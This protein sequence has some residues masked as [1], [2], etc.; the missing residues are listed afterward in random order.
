MAVVGSYD[1]IVG[2]GAISV[3][4]YYVL[5]LIFTTAGLIVWANILTTTEIGIVAGLHIIILGFS[6][7]SNLSLREGVTKFIPEYLT[8]GEKHKA[9]KSFKLSVLLV[10]IVAASIAAFLFLASP[11]L[12]ELVFQGQ[13]EALWIQLSAVDIWLYSVGLVFIGGMWGLNLMPR[14]SLILIISLAIRHGFSSVLVVGGFGIFGI[15]VAYVIGDLILFLAAGVAS[16]LA[17][18]RYNP[19]EFRSSGLSVMSSGEVSARSLLSFS[20]P[21]LASTMM[22]FGLGQLDK[23]FVLAQQELSELGIYNIAVGAALISAYVPSAITIALIPSLSSLTA[24][25]DMV[26]FKELSAAYTRYTSLIAIPMSF[27]LAALATAVLQIFG[28]QY[29][30]GAYPAAIM[31]IATGLTCI[32]AVLSGELIAVKR[33]RAV[34]AAYLSG[35]LAFIA[36]LVFF[37][38][39]MGFVGAAWGRAA[40]YVVLTLVLV[41]ITLRRGLFVIDKKAYLVSIL[42]SMIM[43]IVVFGIVSTIGG[44]RRQIAALPMLVLLGAFIYVI[45]LRATKILK[46]DDIH[47]LERLLPKKLGWMARWV[48]RL[49]GL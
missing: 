44:Y 35:L 8:L 36:M 30:V 15:L 31:S 6:F 24:K 22:L 17:L 42:A 26:G 1:A 41:G 25:E 38:P 16:F 43:G 48:A 5:S 2:R 27:G 37:V 14:A 12:A 4:S 11:I 32:N 23:I 46:P 18:Y 10:A 29:K 19:P 13:A 45:V 34:M 7:L 40:M 3:Y 28:P 49:A 47:F 9:I 20:L 21:L 39:L 33:T